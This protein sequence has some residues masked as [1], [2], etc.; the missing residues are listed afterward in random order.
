MKNKTKYYNV[1]T[2]PISSRQNHQNR[3]NLYPNIKIHDR[4]LSWRGTVTSIKR[5]GVNLVLLAQPHPLL[6][7]CCGDASAYK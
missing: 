1:G 7:K 6:V 5:S 3:Q 4:S 2:A